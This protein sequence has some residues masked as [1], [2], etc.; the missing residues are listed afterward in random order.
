MSA[1]DS[2][3][4]RI[5]VTPRSLTKHGHPALDELRAAGYEIVPGPAGRM[6]TAAELTELLPGCVGYLAGVEEISEQV[7]AAAPELRAISRNGVGVDA[8]DREAADRRGV[9]VLTTPGANAQ[10]V[11]ELA[12]GFVFAAARGIVAADRAVKAGEWRR[13]RGLE[14]AGRTLGVI[15]AGNIGRRVLA[16]SR[17]L[18]MES[19]AY[20]PIAVEDP[21]V[22]EALERDG[23]RAVELADLAGRSDVVSLHAPAQGRPLVDAEFLARV[24]PG[25]ILVNTARAALVETEAV[26]EALADGRVGLYATDVFESE[27][28]V[29]RRLAD[30]PNVIATAHVGGYT[31]ESVDRATEAAVRNLITALGEGRR[32]DERFA[33]C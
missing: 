33:V 2:T 29:D 11:A 22:R 32:G 31:A 9:R 18:G 25:L 27:P 4:G 28:P 24:R 14:L 30:H 20:D 16:M 1:T 23:H 3:R 15:G 5:L 13:T 21:A 17:C 19:L 12:I 26:L 10:G 6:P 8:I 7:L